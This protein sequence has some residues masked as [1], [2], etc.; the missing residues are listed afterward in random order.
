MSATSGSTSQQS[1]EGS[2]HA[3]LDRK[4]VAR[5]V[6]Q[7]GPKAIFTRPNHVSYSQPILR[8][9]IMAGI[10]IHGPIASSGSYNILGIEDGMFFL[11]GNLTV[12]QLKQ[13]RSEINKV[14]NGRK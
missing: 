10:S 8:T 3:Q 5:K 7:D 11:Q 13:L 1:T 12:E 6:R 4:L 9:V 2:N 14:L